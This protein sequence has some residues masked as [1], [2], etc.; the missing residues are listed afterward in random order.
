MLNWAIFTGCSLLTLFFLY[1]PS[2]PLLKCLKFRNT[3]SIALSPLLAIA[4]YGTLSIIYGT[5]GIFT[6]FYMLFVPYLI[7]SLA[8]IVLRRKRCCSGI[9]NECNDSGWKW[10]VLYVAIGVLVTIYMFLLPMGDALG[11][12]QNYDDMHHYSVMRNF[13][14]SGNYSI[15]N[16]SIYGDITGKTSFYPAGLHLIVASIA[17]AGNFSLLIAYNAVLFVAVAIIWS[18]GWLYFIKSIFPDGKKFLIFGAVLI[19]VCYAF[20]WNFL[21][22]GRVSPNLLSFCILPS[23]MGVFV[24]SFKQDATKIIVIRGLI[25]VCLIGYVAIFTQPNLIFSMMLLLFAY[26]IETILRSNCALK[27]KSG[28]II[29]SG[30]VAVIFVLLFTLMWLLFYI[31]P[32]SAETRRYNWP[33]NVPFSEAILN[34]FTLT[35][36]SPITFQGVIAGLFVLLGIVYV[37]KSKKNFW[38]IIAYLMAFIDYMWSCLKEGYIKHFIGGFWYTD[39]YRLIAL[40]AIS[41]I[42]L[43]VCGGVFL[44]D[45][46]CSILKSDNKNKV[47]A[48][49]LSLV[50]V[51]AIILLSPNITL[52][53]NQVFYTTAGN[54]Q[55]KVKNLLSIS[56]FGNDLFLN[57][58]KMEFLD[59][60][61]KITG[62]DLVENSPLDGS[63]L[64]FQYNGIKTVHRHIFAGTSASKA[65]MILDNELMLAEQIDRISVDPSIKKLAKKDNIKYVLKLSNNEMTYPEVPWVDY[66]YKYNISKFFPGVMNIDDNTPG[67]KKVLERGEMRLYEIED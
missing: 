60:V 13:L 41:A 30:W 29:Q 58:D 15:L 20:P 59:E 10:I 2:F 12:G 57:R 53:S 65:D 6:N 25:F 45:S 56:D 62:D 21:V 54:I 46:I 5:L 27:L 1:A 67:F 26:C 35:H 19:F 9:S 32:F 63:V 42:P 14:D 36:A 17:S 33:S 55:T 44:Y 4:I 23:G 11:M 38:L 39:Q 31:A 22:Y 8:I 40:L 16:T 37:I 43:I 51:F 7:V 64:A 49:Q 34:A 66:R 3:A 18:T 47:L 24:S 50:G 48:C 28:K 61:H 52:S